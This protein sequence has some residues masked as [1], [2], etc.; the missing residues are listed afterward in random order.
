MVNN[1]LGQNIWMVPFDQI[2]NMLYVSPKH[3]TIEP[4]KAAANSQ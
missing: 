1:G 4:K 3:L 2:T